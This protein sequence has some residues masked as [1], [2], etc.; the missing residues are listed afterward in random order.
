M[1][2]KT[3]DNSITTVMGTE[4]GDQGFIFGCGRTHFSPLHHT[5]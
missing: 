3:M 1:T 4:L 2:G 5:I